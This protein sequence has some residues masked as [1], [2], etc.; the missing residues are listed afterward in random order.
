MKI[1]R[2]SEY[3]KKYLINKNEKQNWNQYW[4]LTCH[5]PTD[6]TGGN[7][8]NP[9]VF[10]LSAPQATLKEW[11]NLRA[12]VSTYRGYVHVY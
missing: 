11:I 7:Q 6:H 12:I 3:D 2:T 10:V 8:W 4:T 9:Q 1:I 5:L